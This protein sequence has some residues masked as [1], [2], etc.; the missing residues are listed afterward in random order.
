MLTAFFLLFHLSHLIEDL[1]K[2]SM[3]CATIYVVAANMNLALQSFV[4]AQSKAEAKPEF[5]KNLLA[6]LDRGVV[7]KIRSPFVGI[8]LPENGSSQVVGPI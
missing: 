6:L 2:L 3:L 5:I 1:L 8:E 4:S 7:A